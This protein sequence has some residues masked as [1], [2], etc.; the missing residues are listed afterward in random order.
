[1]VPPKNIL[2]I[3]YF[4]V[5]FLFRKHTIAFFYSDFRKQYYMS[6]NLSSK[7]TTVLSPKNILALPPD[8]SLPEKNTMS[9]SV[10]KKY[11]CS[12]VALSF[13]R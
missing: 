4:F 10:A 13:N 5:A 6:P 7:N 12:T 2:T 9:S 1:M 11:T 8:T 3:L